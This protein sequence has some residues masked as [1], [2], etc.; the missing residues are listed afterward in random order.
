MPESEAWI[1]AKIRVALVALADTST[2][3]LPLSTIQRLVIGYVP[4]TVPII[5]TVRPAWFVAGESETEL[6]L[7]NGGGANVWIEKLSILLPLTRI[8]SSMFLKA[9]IAIPSKGLAQNEHVINVSLSVTGD[10]S[11]NELKA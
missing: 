4:A 2:R 9:A 11:A 1:L 5:F 7:R 8:E 6:T 10:P 3:P